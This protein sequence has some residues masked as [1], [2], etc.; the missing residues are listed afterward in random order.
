MAKKAKQ[1]IERKGVQVVLRV[2]AEVRALIEK[3]AHEG[4][5]SMNAAATARLATGRWPKKEEK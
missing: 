1:K 2:P 5:T 4:Y 3:M